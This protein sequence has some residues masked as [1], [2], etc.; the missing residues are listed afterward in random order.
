MKT[1]TS[2]RFITS[3]YV[4][5]VL[6]LLLVVVVGRLDAAT[7]RIDSANVDLTDNELISFVAGGVSYSQ[8]DLIQP[9]L[10]E[11]SG[12]F[13]RNISVPLGGSVPAPGT[14]S[15]LLT[16]DFNLDTGI[17]NPAVGA[18]VATLQFSPP[19]INGSGPDLVMFEINSNIPNDFLMQIN[20]NTMTYLGT[21]YDTSLLT[22][23]VQAFIRDAGTTEN[24]FQLENDSYSTEATGTEDV[25]GIAINLDDFGVN[26]LE[27]V[28]SVHFGS[29]PDSSTIDPMLF[30]GLNGSFPPMA[31]FNS[32]N[33]V[34]GDDLGILETGFGAVD[35]FSRPL[36]E[37][38][39]ADE[40]GDIDGSDFLIWQREY[41]LGVASSA[42]SANVPEPTTL[43]LGALAVVGLLV[44]R[45]SLNLILICDSLY[46]HTK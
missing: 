36:H 12:S 23:S 27:M 31:D 6:P 5:L 16:H 46:F 38:G 25:Y 21:S 3:L 45:R 15:L 32:D 1:T 30:M 35:P 9:T 42:S 37:F 4:A 19:L 34:D 22:V 20:G 7:V 44:R 17:I 10:T 24:I 29:A 18:T 39:D 13:A 40:D 43:L 8:S 41:G 33:K 14:R 28:S 11:F 2:F 26:P